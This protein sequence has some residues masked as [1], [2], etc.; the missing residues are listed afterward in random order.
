MKKAWIFATLAL[1]TSAAAQHVVVDPQTGKTI[2]IYEDKQQSDSQINEM[3][4]TPPTLDTGGF[5]RG[6]QA[7]QERRIRQNEIEKQE[8]ELENLRLQNELLKE[9]AKSAE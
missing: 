3:I 4:A 9:R 5:D 1:S 8:L 7:A 6:V 2:Y